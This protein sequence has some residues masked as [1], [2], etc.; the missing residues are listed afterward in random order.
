MIVTNS[1]EYVNVLDV[2]MEKAQAGTS[3]VLIVF[4]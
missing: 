3:E 2:P 1:D 4:Q